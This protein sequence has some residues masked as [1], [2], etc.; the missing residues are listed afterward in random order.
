MLGCFNLSMLLTL[1][2]LFLLHDFSIFFFCLQFFPTNCFRFFVEVE[3][4]LLAVWA[5]RVCLAMV[6]GPMDFLP[7]EKGGLFCEFLFL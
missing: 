5:Y 3:V 1:L 4:D 6:G 7:Y 2:A